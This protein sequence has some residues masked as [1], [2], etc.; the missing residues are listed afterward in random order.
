[1]KIAIIMPALNEER[2][3]GAVISSIPRDDVVQILVADNGSTDRTAAVATRSGAS[4][5][6]AS[7]RGYGHA[8]L[9]ALRQLDPEVDTVVFLDSDGSDYPEDLPG[10]LQPIRLNQ[11]DLV[12]GSRLLGNCQPGA[13]P[14]HQWWGNWI[15]GRLIG[16]LYGETVTDLGPFRV[17]RRSL[18]EK[19]EMQ[20]AAFRW[21][22]EMLVKTLRHRGRVLELPVRYRTRVGV[23]KIS[24]TLKGSLLAGWA[25][26]TTAL[27]YA[28]GLPFY[29]PRPGGWQ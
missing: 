29:R 14:V 26:L 8:C 15:A 20:P 12:I 28:P 22:T 9:A 3:I 23:S 11:A 21:T 19:L 4:V 5:V 2:A 25:I 24:G 1:M 10:L 6:P 27:Y 17:I 7:V 18:L 13:L 16:W